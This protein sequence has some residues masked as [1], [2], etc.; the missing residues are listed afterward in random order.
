M[1]FEKLTR[2]IEFLGRIKL[3]SSFSRKKRLSNRR[4][5]RGRIRVLILTRSI[6]MRTVITKLMMLMMM[7]MVMLLMLMLMMVMEMRRSRRRRS[8]RWKRRSSSTRSGVSV[9]AWV[10]KWNLEETPTS[11]AVGSWFLL[12]HSHLLLSYRWSMRIA[13]EKGLTREESRERE[14]D[15]TWDGE[16]KW[17]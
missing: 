4:N 6:T 16:R 11:F 8:S 2:K 10:T 5:W 14:R 15:R 9:T 1:R 12:R 3:Q 17:I 7:V 13:T